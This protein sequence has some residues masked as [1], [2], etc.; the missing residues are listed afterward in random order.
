M[1]TRDYSCGAAALATVLRYY[2]GDPVGEDDVLIVLLK[3]LTP[4]ETKD[5]FKH[6]LAISDLRRAAVDM[7]YLSTIG[8]ISL[9][10]L[11]QAR[12][13]VVVALKIKEYDHFV[14]YRGMCDGRVYL[15]DP[16]RGNVRPTIPEFN[17]QWQKN[18][19]LVVVKPGTAPP[20]QSA[21]SIRADEVGVG[22]MTAEMLRKQ[23]PE[24]LLH[25]LP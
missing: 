16:I 22:D 5:R 11:S 8:T 10:Q 18:A 6:G 20:L 17:G 21:L 24:P 23:L 15:A 14:V 19:I 2:W 13:P 7:G 25:H 4:E 9:Q 12:A 3:T 1:Q